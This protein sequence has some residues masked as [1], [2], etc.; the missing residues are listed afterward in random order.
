MD[1]TVAGW[2]DHFF[3]L[4]GPAPGLTDIAVVSPAIF[5]D[6]ALKKNGSAV[7]WSDSPATQGQIFSN[8][9]AISD[10]PHHCIALRQDGKVLSYGA[11]GTLAV[12]APEHLTNV[13]AIAA[14]GDPAFDHDLALRRDGTVVAWGSR[15]PVHQTEMPKDLTNVTAIAAGACHSLALRKDGTVVAWGANVSGQI[16]LPE[17]LSNI[18]AIAAGGASSAAVVL[19]PESRSLMSRL[20]THGSGKVF[21]AAAIVSLAAACFWL[22]RRRAI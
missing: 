16:A 5:Y 14:W 15:G 10:A 19:M 1:G 7:I 2:G 9:V 6:M 18:I 17:S 11:D 20:K 8:A 12:P 22:L 13:I 21:M 3:G 4:T